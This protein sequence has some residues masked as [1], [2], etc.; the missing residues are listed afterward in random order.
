MSNDKNK[1]NRTMIFFLSRDVREGGD[2]SLG[3]LHFVRK[4]CEARPGEI[5]NAD[6]DERE[7]P[8][9]E[10]GKDIAKRK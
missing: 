6:E 4:D 8:D 10:E 1:T 5:Q 9:E 3:E 2:R 7:S